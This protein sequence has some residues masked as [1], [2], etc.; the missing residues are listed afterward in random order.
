MMPN[1]GN[2]ITRIPDQKAFAEKILNVNG[3]HI[4]RFCASWSGPCQIMAPVYEEMSMLF[5]HSVSFYRIDI[6]EA[7]LLKKEFA[8]TELPTIL[9][10]KNGILAEH[11]VG[12]ISRELFKEKINHFIL[13]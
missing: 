5:Q 13:S 11:A 1:Q 3:L 9:F 6:D 10:Y 8:I 7:P 4:V 2:M 12:L